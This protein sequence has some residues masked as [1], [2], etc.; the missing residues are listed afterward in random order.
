[1][2]KK[3]DS[4][5]SRKERPS[6]RSDDDGHVRVKSKF[7][8]LYAVNTNAAVQ[9][10]GNIS[11][12][13]TTGIL[14]GDVSLSSLTDMFRLYK[15]N[16][17]TFEF[18]PATGIGAATVQVPSGFLGFVPFGCAGTP[19]S[20]ADFETNLVSKTSF[21]YAS[22]TTTLAAPLT[23]ECE[24]SLTL[25]NA[26]MPVLQGPGGGWLATQDDGTQGYFGK[27]FWAL[28]STTASNVMQY[29]LR[30]TFDISFK[31]L[32][33]P[34]LISKLM[35]RHPTGFPTTWSVQ[36][37]TPLAHAG[38][39]LRSC[40]DVPSMTPLPQP[41]PDQDEDSEPNVN[42]WAYVQ[43]SGLQPGG[44]AASRLL[45]RRRGEFLPPR[46]GKN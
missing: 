3:A 8:Q 35:S 15:I 16:S 5:R 11:P 23:K 1:M 14:A 40:R 41:L 13:V 38:A 26:D 31:D 22:T 32:L 30:T 7:S 6:A 2:V 27:L 20:I 29:L 12:A 37:N 42:D 4:N 10:I 36:P 25:K 17:I 24:T 33:D 18:L 39:L 34:A 43:A 45:L 28:A 9:A 44:A 21:P 19:A 46:T